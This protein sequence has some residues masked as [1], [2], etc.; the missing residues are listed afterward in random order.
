MRRLLLPL[1]VV[2][3]TAWAAG[4]NKALKNAAKAIDAAERSVRRA[5]PACGVLEGRFDQVS[6]AV[7]D[8]RDADD[9]DAWTAQRLQQQVAQLSSSAAFVRCPDD[10]L[11]NL[12]RASDLLEAAR[13]SAW[14]NRRPPGPPRDDDDF[15]NR[16]GFIDTPRVQTAVPFEGE[17]AARVTVPRLTLNNMRG[18]RFYLAARWRSLGGNWSDWVATEQ[19]TVPSDP[20]VWPNAFT[21]FVHYSALADEDFAQGRFVVQVSVFDGRGREITSRDA[22]FVVQSRQ[23]L[24]PPPQPGLV[25]PPPPPQQLARDCGT[26]PQDP[27]CMMQRNGRWAMDGATWRGVYGSLRDQ[28]NEIVRFDMLKSM[29]DAQG[30]SAAQL[31]L[32][33]DLFDNEIYRFDVAKFCAPRV[34][35]PMHAL[36]LSNKFSNSIYQRDYVDLMSK[37]R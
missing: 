14:S 35:N 17:L 18:Q 10:V 27:G 28:M 1:L 16:S 9:F 25:P 6:D 13:A 37:Q 20:F 7:D 5:A 30:L 34:V 32:L 11:Q 24:P 4:P 33:L 8:A 26:G 12:S 21:H 36:G 29:L 2:S 31:G 15:R 3:L 23:L 19:W 22:A